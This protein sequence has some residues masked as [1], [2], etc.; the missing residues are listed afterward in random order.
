MLLADVDLMQFL[1]CYK[2]Q[3]QPD[4]EQFLCA[5]CHS[6]PS[7]FLFLESKEHNILEICHKYFV[8]LVLHVKNFMKYLSILLFCS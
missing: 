2:M 4:M 6:A 1:H 3:H 5:L 7:T 8:S